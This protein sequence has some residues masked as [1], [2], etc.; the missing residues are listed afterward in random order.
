[1]RRPGQLSQHFWRREFA[2]K[3][4]CGFDTVD[5]ELV[6]VLETIRFEL[7]EKGIRITSGC[8]CAEHN[9]KIGGSPQSQHLL[10]K[11]ADF[12]V[13][14]VHADEVGNLIE[15]WWPD[16]YGMGR[17]NGRTHIDVRR[18]HSRWDLRK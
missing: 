3:C 4:G 9:A 7:G 18:K 16:H 12:V 2:C 11:A 15:L 10:G 5:A 13:S 14:G 8:R 17:Y 6:D 1:M